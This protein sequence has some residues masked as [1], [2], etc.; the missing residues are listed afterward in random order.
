VS[1]ADDARVTIALSDG[2]EAEAVGAQVATLISTSGLTGTVTEV[3][4]EGPPGGD[5][6]VQLSGD[7]FAALSAAADQVVAALA[8]IDGLA[9]VSSNVAAPRTELA[10]AVDP[11]R[12]SDEGVSAGLVAAS[13]R[14]ALN[15]I[16]AGEIEIDGLDRA[17]E[18]RVDPDSVAGT[19]ALADWEVVPD[20][21]VGEVAEV[22]EVASPATV[23]HF[24]GDRSVE[25]RG[26]ITSQ[27]TAAVSDLA[28]R[29]IGELDLPEGIDVT[30]GGITDD[31]AE[32]V[33]GMLVAMVVAVGLVYL[34][35]CGVFGSLLTPFVILFS[36]PLAAI[37]AFPLLAVTGRE[38]GL[39]T[40]I[41]VLM[42]I[43]LVVANAIVLIDF[44]EARRREGAST[45]DAL[46]DAAQ[47]RL[48]PIL[49]TAV[50]TICALVPLALGFSQGALLS[51]SLATVVIGGM[52]SATALTLIVVPVVYSLV[53]DLRGRLAGARARATP[54]GRGVL[55]LDKE[56]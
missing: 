44:V 40:L 36:I 54:D 16:P 26:V 38:L 28:T 34:A 9:Q 11:E 17:I 20:V 3:S 32:S 19:E 39:P 30:L 31:L 7:D 56:Q 53:D 14:A 12:A 42:L 22:V 45:S 25:V 49:M 52:V 51:A 35:M 1:D 50:S 15:T 55:A 48:R 23:T 2:A 41:G 29:L 13:V 10:V 8:G 27:D 5:L 4:D 46:L 37:G 21:T 33:S 43:G 18:V 6:S 24:D 47:I